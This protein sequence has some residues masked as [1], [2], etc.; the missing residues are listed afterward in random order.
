LRALVAVF[1]TAALIAGVLTIVAREQSQ[2]ASREAR[3]ASARELAAAAI[4]N[5]D[6]DP[7][8]SILLAIQAVRETRSTDGT[9]LPESEAALHRAVTASRVVRTVPG[10]GGHLDW[11][12]TG[13]F[14]TEGAEGSG[15]IDIRSAST[16]K[17]V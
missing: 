17:R 9:V 4:A 12:P 8:R 3:I 11:S 14:V 1:A 6:V 7:E 5:L 2:R 16:G 15:M 10:L 13:V